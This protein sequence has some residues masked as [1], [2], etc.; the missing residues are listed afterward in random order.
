MTNDLVRALQV[1]RDDKSASQIS[2]QR[3]RGRLGGRQGHVRASRFRNRLATEGLHWTNA[4]VR[5][6][7][8]S[9]KLLSIEKGRFYES[10]EARF[11]EANRR[12][13]IGRNS[14]RKAGV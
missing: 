4:G 7:R 12:W 14:A 11:Y 13:G 6:C 1:Q 5:D 9:P 8:V 3:L 10:I 2:V